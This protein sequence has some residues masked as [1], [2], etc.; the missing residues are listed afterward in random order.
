LFFG[1]ESYF[2]KTDLVVAAHAG[3]GGSTM[4]VVG[5]AF[6]VQFQAFGTSAVA[7]LVHRRVLRGGYHLR[8]GLALELRCSLNILNL[9]AI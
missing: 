4:A 8:E 9:A 2:F 3:T 5:K 7:W 1:L 6:T